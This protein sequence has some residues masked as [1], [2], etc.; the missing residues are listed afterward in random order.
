M[1]GYQNECPFLGQADPHH[2]L[3]PKIQGYPQRTTGGSPLMYDYTISE[4][5]SVFLGLKP[6]RLYIPYL[7]YYT[8]KRG[9]NLALYWVP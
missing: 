3:H 4:L 1:L 2:N 6:V 7:K 9:Y 5:F 8:P